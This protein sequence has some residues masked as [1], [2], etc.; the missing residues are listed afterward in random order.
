MASAGARLEALVY[1]FAVLAFLLFA[2]RDAFTGS[3]RYLFTVLHV[4]FVWFIP[5]LMAFAALIYFAVDQVQRRENLLGTL[6]VATFLFS[7]VV[8]GIFMKGSAV[9][10]FSAVKMFIPIFAGTIMFGRSITETP[11]ARNVLLFTFLASAA[12]LILSPHV[13]FPWAGQTIDAYGI[14]RS[15]SKLWWEAGG[16]RYGGFAGDSTM[17]AFMVIFPYFLIHRYYRLL[18]NVVFF[19]I[20]LYAV[21]VSTSKTA[22]IILLLFP[23]IPLVLWRGAPEF[24]LKRLR[25][26]T[27]LSFLTLLIPPLAIV[28][29]GGVDLTEISTSLYSMADRINNSWQL[30]FSYLL[31]VF[32]AGL[33]VGCGLGCFSYPMTYT[34]M[35]V[36][37]VPVDNFYLST[38]LM[39]GYPFLIFTL[40]LAYGVRHMTNVNKLILLLVFNVYCVSI[41]CYGP[42]F[43]T[44]V[45]GYA[46]SD[47]FAFKSRRIAGVERRSVTP[48]AGT[49]TTLAALRG[50]Q[51]YGSRPAQ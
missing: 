26:L 34:S 24:K 37:D 13:D 21:Q 2:V 22:L 31:D 30:P 47:A 49:S 9:G 38:Y 14:E 7:T 39:M 50:T 11:L 51:S 41:Q 33:F 48:Q 35:G 44:L 4:D 18:P 27:Q 1:K 29:V 5:D 46:I 43:A 10:I 40:L 23:L 19:L 36:Y 6:L 25:T 3:I 20:A 28:L 45:W 42:S 12:G 15:A 32:P 17:A 16:V 8:G